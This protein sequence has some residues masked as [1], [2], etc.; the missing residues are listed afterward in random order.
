MSTGSNPKSSETQEGRRLAEAVSSVFSWRRWGPYV[1][2]RSW[3]TVREDYSADGNAWSF[4]SH[5]PSGLVNRKW[6]ELPDPGRWPG[7]C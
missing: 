2:E 4:L 7:L 5:A 3:G 1:S 6:G